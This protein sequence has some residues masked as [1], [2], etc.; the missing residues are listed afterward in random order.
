MY[1]ELFIKHF[2]TIKTWLFMYRDREQGFLDKM[3]G[4]FYAWNS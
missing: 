3:Y 4:H 1:S 2:Y